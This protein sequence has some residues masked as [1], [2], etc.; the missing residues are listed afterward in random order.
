LEFFQKALALDTRNYFAAN[1]IG[2]V[3]A[4]KG[5]LKE[6]KEIFLQVRQAEGDFDDVWVNMG[7]VF[8]ELSSYTTAV[9][10]VFIS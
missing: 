1:G 7:H 9:S 5:H 3:L 2:I 8:M 6:A 4:A 10:M